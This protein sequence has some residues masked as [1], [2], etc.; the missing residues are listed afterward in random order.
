MELNYDELQNLLEKIKDI[1]KFVDAYNVQRKANKLFLANGDVID[2]KFQKNCL[3]HL[4]GVNIDY[5]ISTGLFNSKTSY[6]MLNEICENGYRLNSYTKRGI[7]NYDCIFSKH[8]MEKLEKLIQNIKISIHDTQLVCKYDSKRSYYINSKNEKFDYAVIKKYEDNKIG[9]LTLVKRNNYYVPMSN[10]L[11]NSFEDL[12]ETNKELLEN[13]TITILGGLIFNDE[14]TEY[15]KNIYLSYDEKI[16]KLDSLKE[17]VS[18]FN[19]VIDITGDYRFFLNKTIQ[20]KNSKNFNYELTDFIVESIRNGKIIDK[21]IYTDT[22]LISI[23][24]AFNDYLCKSKVN[25]D[26]SITNSYSKIA[27]E[28][29]S[30]KEEMA[31]LLIE[32]QSLISENNTLKENN[33]RLI[34]DNSEFDLREKEIIKILEKRRNYNN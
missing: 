30:L 15:S 6:D 27:Y 20:N 34:K 23:I 12:K 10:Q 29:K 14:I 31:K 4:V 22:Y 1:I 2:Y 7:L 24:D 32:K 3:A 16:K 25:S 19:T 9:V 17:Y 26:E 18:E 28:L 8:I 13:Q 5:L 21:N 33:E 11:Y